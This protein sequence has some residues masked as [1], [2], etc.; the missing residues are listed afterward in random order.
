MVYLADLLIRGLVFGGKQIEFMSW[1]RLSE[2]ASF[3]KFLNGTFPWRNCTWSDPICHNRDLP[4]AIQQVGDKWFGPLCDSYLYLIA[5]N[6]LHIFLVNWPYS[7][8]NNLLFTLLVLFLIMHFFQVSFFV[9]RRPFL[10]C[11]S[12]KLIVVG[13]SFLSER[14]VIVVYNIC[15]FIGRRR[16]L[17]LTK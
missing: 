7:R 9:S 16:K 10:K 15:Y 5:Y 17:M 13:S 14:K 4:W 3:S 12:R 11:C 6:T 1:L 8:P 2:K